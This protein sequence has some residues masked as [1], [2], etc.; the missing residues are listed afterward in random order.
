MRRNSCIYWY[1]I[2]H[3]CRICKF[4]ILQSYCA[5]IVTLCSG[6][7]NLYTGNRTVYCLSVWNS[8]CPYT[9]D[10][11]INCTGKGNCNLAAIPYRAVLS[12]FLLKINCPYLCR[13]CAL[14][15][16]L[17]LAE[18]EICNNIHASLKAGL[19]RWL[20]QQI[21]CKQNSFPGDIVSSHIKFKIVI[22][23]LP[24]TLRVKHCR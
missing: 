1:A 15:P 9:I 24:F 13:Y 2:I 7:I 14:H 4:R 22:H 23:P 20:Y 3:V 10:I 5:I 21:R 12:G 17:F 11:C 6:N 19:W 16:T 18:Q 8:F